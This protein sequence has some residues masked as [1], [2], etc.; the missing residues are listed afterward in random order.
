[1][2]RTTTAQQCRDHARSRLAGSRQPEAAN[3]SAD[4]P[5]DQATGDAPTATWVFTSGAPS[6][7]VRN[8]WSFF[9]RGADCLVL[10]VTGAK[11]DSFGQRTFDTAAHSF[12]VLPLPPDRQREVDLLAGMGFLERRD[13]AAA[14]D[15]FDDVANEI[16]GIVLENV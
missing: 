16:H 8:R 10:H 9:A 3:A 6:A 1:M 14:L 12:Q 7:P 13:P 4:A 11:D 2:T 15:R 5:R